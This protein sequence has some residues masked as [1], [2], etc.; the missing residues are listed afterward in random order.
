VVA[1]SELAGQLAPL[2][3]AMGLELYDLELAA[4][5][6]RVTVTRDGGVDLDTLT[7][8]NHRLSAWLDQHDPM[9]GRYTLEV[10]SPGL[11]RR[12]RTPAQFKGAVGETVT[13]RIAPPDRA[14]ERVTGTLT[15]ATD[16]GVELVT[17][18][19]PR[20]AGYDEVERARTVFSWGPSPKPSPSRGKGRGRASTAREA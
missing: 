5:S 17:D 15:A 18:A 19:G 13:L 8:A 3:G 6:L 7:D 2:L 9:P 11:E 16:R 4:G 1:E 10:S 12:L 20:A 14:A